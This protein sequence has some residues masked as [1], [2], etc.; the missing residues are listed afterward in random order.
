MSGM[1]KLLLL[2]VLVAVLALAYSAK[3]K[4]QDNYED[5]E[6]NMTPRGKCVWK[7]KRSD[8][9]GKYKCKLNKS[10]RE[11][12][13]NF[14]LDGE[15]C[16]ENDCCAYNRDEGGCKELDHCDWAGRDG[17]LPRED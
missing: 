7:P 3:C 9:T 13:G 12:E 6:I 15:R 2:G 16:G 14:E 11:V 1:N 4:D 8:G 17:C 5:C 10:K